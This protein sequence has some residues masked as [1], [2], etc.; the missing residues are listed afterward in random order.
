V[1]KQIAEALAA[2]CFNL[3]DGNEVINLL[4]VKFGS[5]STGELWELARELARLQGPPG[6]PQ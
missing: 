4:V 6:R 1:V 2:E 3:D 5:P